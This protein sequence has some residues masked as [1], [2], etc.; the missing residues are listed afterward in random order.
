MRHP[1]RARQLLHQRLEAPQTVSHPGLELELSGARTLIQERIVHAA[2]ILQVVQRL[3][4]DGLRHRTQQRG[5]LWQRSRQLG[6]RGAMPG[7]ECKDGRHHGGLRA[8][9]LNKDPRGSAG[10]ARPVGQRLGPVQLDEPLG[11]LADGQRQFFPII[12]PQLDGQVGQCH[13]KG[14]LVGGREVAFGEYA[15]E[16][17]QKHELRLGR[18]QGMRCHRATVLSSSLPFAES[19][20]ARRRA[21]QV[22]RRHIAG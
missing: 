19:P 1:V 13:Q 15:L 11:N 12:G 3:R 5:V 2:K 18:W 7:P 22:G 16:F 17:A 8:V 4:R 6:R 21:D 10:A 14:K 20:S 9:V